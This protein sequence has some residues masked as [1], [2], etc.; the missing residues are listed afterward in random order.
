MKRS[1][2]RRTSRPR[3]VQLT[4]EKLEDRCVPATWPVGPGVAN[5]HQ[6]RMD[7]GQAEPRQ[8]WVIHRGIDIL[9]DGQGG[10]A[11]RAARAGTVVTNNNYGGGYVVIRVPVGVG[12]SST[13]GTC[14]S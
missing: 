6:I 10:Q 4:V 13:T 1:Q 12:T 9:V 5:D 3:R 7:Y 8:N 2:S 14:M 11:V